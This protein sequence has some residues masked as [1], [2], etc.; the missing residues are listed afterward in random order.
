MLNLLLQNAELG[1]IDGYYTELR[2]N[3]LKLPEEVVKQ[4]PLLIKALATVYYLDG[5]TRGWARWYGALRKCA[6]GT[7]GKKRKQAEVLLAY[8]DLLL[9]R[10]DLVG[11]TRRLKEYARLQRSAEMKLPGFSP[12]YAFPSVLDG[13]RDC[14]DW[15]TL[16]IDARRRE[17][18]GL[19]K[20]LGEQGRGIEQEF[21]AE[22]SLELGNANAETLQRLVQVDREALRCQS[23]EL[24][25]AALATRCRLYMQSGAQAS[26]GALLRSFEENY[27]NFETNAEAEGA[28]QESKEKILRRVRLNFEALRCR[29]ALYE[30]DRETLCLWMQKAPDEHGKF[31]SLERYRYVT[32]IRCYI[33]EE[34][35]VAALDLIE[36]LKSFAR[37]YHRTYLWQELRILSAIV[38]RRTG[39]A[40][41][42]EF[43]AA[44]EQL[45]RY[46]LTGLLADYG[47]EALGL[48]GEC[49]AEELPDA[50][51]VKQARERMY[52][53]ARLYPVYLSVAQVE[54]K[55]VRLSE[56][57]LSILRLQEQ[58]ATATEI[59][60]KLKMNLPNVK[61]HIKEN[62]R[63][64]DVN[65]KLQAVLKARRWGLI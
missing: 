16:D 21:L 17:L 24:A 50:D 46:G 31:S 39:E 6:K 23:P 38:L 58:G 25:L 60:K 43:T 40:W 27:L 19:R 9:R 11:T 8:G 55:A 52:R 45:A 53:M 29:A 14:C 26:I 54:E 4:S 33:A 42:A 7:E 30:N 51:F 10:S 2:Q 56:T 18:D 5:N 15:V 13:L 32:K 65:T 20:A 44:L 41:K 57:A 63:K 28:R 61:Y 22:R 62:Y 59:A 34:N 35:Y 37:Q 36:R 64:L 1:A 47:A 49:R 12:L 48:L 3:Y